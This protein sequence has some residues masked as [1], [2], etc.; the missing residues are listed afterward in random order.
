[1]PAFS[2]KLVILSFLALSFACQSRKTPVVTTAHTGSAVAKIIDT[3]VKFKKGDIDT[4]LYN[5]LPYWDTSLS[6]NS[7]AYEDTFS[8]HETGFRIIHPGNQ[9]TFIVEKMDNENWVVQFD[10]ENFENSVGYDRMKDLNLDGYND[11]VVSGRK[12][13]SVFFFNPAIKAFTYTPGC[14]IVTMDWWLIDTGR[15]WY[16]EVYPKNTV[17]SNLFTFKG[18]E[19][20]DLL[21]MEFDKGDNEMLA[22]AFLYN[23]YN[24][25]P[26]KKL[27]FTGEFDAYDFNY[28]SCWKKQFK[29]VPGFK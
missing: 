27:K 16:A 19:R 8:I 1:M 2:P 25:Q 12:F 13:G 21:R 26:L 4:G 9:S 20:V 10:T 22:N 23:A 6:Y 18:F 28:D 3:L 17:V 15:N 29:Y 11:L 7:S 5:E 24:E 14:D